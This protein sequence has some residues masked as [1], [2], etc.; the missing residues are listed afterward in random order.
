MAPVSF[1]SNERS[2][3]RGLLPLDR[4]HPISSD[5]PSKTYSQPNT[6]PVQVANFLQIP[7]FFHHHHTPTPLAATDATGLHP[8][9][10]LPTACQPKFH[11]ARCKGQRGVAFQKMVYPRLR[12][13]SCCPISTNL[14]QRSKRDVIYL[15]LAEVKAVSCEARS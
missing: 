4:K 6:W 14:M 9:F 5:L 1:F 7:H 11:L 3:Q 8:A 13:Q 2:V 15:I 10:L 12:Q